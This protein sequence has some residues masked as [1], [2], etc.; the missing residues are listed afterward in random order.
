MWIIW[1]GEFR[2]SDRG[3]RGG[4]A[5]GSA[6][7]GIGLCVEA[8]RILRGFRGFAHRIRRARASDSASGLARPLG[9]RPV[10][11]RPRVSNSARAAIPGSGPVSKSARPAHRPSTGSPQARPQPRPG[12]AH[13]AVHRPPTGRG[14]GRGRRLPE[15]GP[16]AP[17]G[18]RG[19]IPAGVRAGRTARAA[20]GR[21]ESGR[22]NGDESWESWDNPPPPPES[23]D[24]N[25][26]RRFG[27]SPAGSAVQRQASS[28]A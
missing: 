15:T 17:G 19:G 27:T 26:A 16:A 11:R 22:D 2:G 3:L 18:R 23:R 20:S 9:N 28:A 12:R 25:R 13:R 24:R 14:R 6:W 8:H 1:R 10:S 5:Y 4:R 21:P 7:E